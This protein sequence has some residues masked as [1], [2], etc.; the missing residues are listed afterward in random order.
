MGK[1]RSGTKG[2]KELPY[3][4]GFDS[5]RKFFQSAHTRPA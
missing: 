1:E 5:S 2:Q 3:L 4:H